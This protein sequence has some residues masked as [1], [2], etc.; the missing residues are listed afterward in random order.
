VQNRITSYAI[1]G[2]ATKTVAYDALGNITAKS[3]VGT[4][5]YNASGSASVRPHAV[6]AITPSGT[7]TTNTTYT[8]DA[9][10]NMLT[11]NGRTA[12]WTSFNMVA[13]IT[14]GTNT[15]AISLLS[16]RHVLPGYIRKKDGSRELIPG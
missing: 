9:N 15:V 7:G 10:G 3:D 14:R 13:S 6:A 4:Y 12:T 1:I 2:G 11:G 8:Y 5:S 16:S